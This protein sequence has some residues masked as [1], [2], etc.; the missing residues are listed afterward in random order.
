MD[1]A[2]RIHILHGYYHPSKYITA[3]EDKIY[4]NAVHC[5]V[6]KALKASFMLSLKTSF[7]F[8]MSPDWESRIVDIA[9]KSFWIGV[10]KPTLETPKNEANN[11]TKLS[12]SRVIPKTEK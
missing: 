1:G 7:N 12:F 11:A 6:N 9:K 10:D 5:D 3:N 2:R 8:A 4:S